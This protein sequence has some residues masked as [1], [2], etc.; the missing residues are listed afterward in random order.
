MSKIPSWRIIQWML[1]LVGLLVVL[2]PELGG[3]RLTGQI[4]TVFGFVIWFALDMVE[5]INRKTI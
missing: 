4:A 1:I 3:D 2:F 5:E